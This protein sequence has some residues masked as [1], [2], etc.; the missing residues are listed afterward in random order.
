MLLGFLGKDLRMHNLAYARRIDYAYAGLF[1]C[2][3]AAAQKP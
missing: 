2:V 3:W 1:F